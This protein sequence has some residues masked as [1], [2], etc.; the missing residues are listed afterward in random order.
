MNLM[1]GLLRPS[2]GRVSRAR[3]EPRTT[4]R[5]SAARSATARSSTP[6]RGA[7]PARSFIA[8]VAAPVTALRAREAERAHRG[9]PRARGHDRGRGPQGR[10]LQQG[11]AA[12][13]PAR[14]GA[15]HRPEVLVL[16]EPL[17]GLDP[18]ARAETIALFQ[19]LGA[20]GAARHRLEP[21]PPRGRP[22]LRPRGPAEPRLRRGR[23]ADPRRAQRG[24]GAPDADPGALRR[25]PH[26]AGRAACSGETHVVE[27]KIHADG[28]GLLV[29][30]RDADRLLPAAEPDRARGPGSSSRRS[31]PPTTTSARS[32]ST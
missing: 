26:R 25:R 30:T 23:G 1:T 5:P 4:R 27:V 8:G 17:N 11:D 2:R 28:K 16:D 20:R 7:S 15:R 21:H 18:M 22:H 10:R 13:H 24:H 19:G 29:R 31:R 14:A 6:S 32:T 3:H 12:A 9:G